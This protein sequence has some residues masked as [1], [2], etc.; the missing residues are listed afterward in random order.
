MKN[1]PV[2]ITSHLET[3]YTPILQEME[4]TAF[5]E[6]TSY[7]YCLKG[8][9]RLYMMHICCFQKLNIN[10]LKTIVTTQL[11]R[12]VGNGEEKIALGSHCRAN[13]RNY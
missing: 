3:L 1:I 4:Q 5:T 8:I 2:N 9:I 6:D 10:R 12:K 11:R 13:N 7:F